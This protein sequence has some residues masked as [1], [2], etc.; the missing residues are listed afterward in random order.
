MGDV[1]ADYPV[2]YKKK[3]GT[4][5]FTK[6][7]IYCTLQ[8]STTPAVTI[9]GAD[10]TKQHVTA[11][12]AAEP[13]LKIDTTTTS[14]TFAFPSSQ[15]RDAVKE[16][17]ATYSANNGAASA[18]AQASSS[19]AMTVRKKEGPG[20]STSPRP[21][22]SGSTVALLKRKRGDV[23]VPAVEIEARKQLLSK[24]P[25]LGKL[26]RELVVTGMVDED[27][28]WEMRRSELETATFAATQKS[29]NL[30]HSLADIRPVE[31]DGNETIV[32]TTEKVHSMFLQNPALQQAYNENVPDKIPEKEFWTR[33]FQSK[34]FY[35]SRRATGS[36]ATLGQSD[37]LFDTLK[38]VLDIDAN[39]DPRRLAYDASNKLV[40]LSLTAEDHQEV[41]NAPDSTMQAGN[42]REYLPVIRKFNRIS[43]D[44]LKQTQ[45]DSNPRKKVDR[46]AK[47]MDSVYA[48]ETE[49][50]ELEAPKEREAQPLAIQEDD[51]FENQAA[52]LSNTTNGNDRHSSQGELDAFSKSMQTWL[53][54][55]SPNIAIFR[56]DAVLRSAT[57]GAKRRKLGHTTDQ[58]PSIDIYPQLVE[59]QNSTLEL[60]RHFWGA[61]SRP[62]KAAKADK[63]AG[64]LR[65]T[66][67][68]IEAFLRENSANPTAVTLM[69]STRQ[70]LEKAIKAYESRTIII[71]YMDAESDLCLI[72]EN[73]LSGTGRRKILRF[74]TM[75]HNRG[76]A[77]AV[78]GHP[79]ADRYAANNPPYWHFDECH[80]HWHFVAYADYELMSADSNNII[81]KGHKN[82]FCLEDLKC[83]P[84]YEKKYTCTNQGITMGCADIYE[85]NLACQWIDITDLDQ[86]PGYSDQTPYTLKVTINRQ[87]FFPELDYGNNARPQALVLI[88]KCRTNSLRPAGGATS[89]DND[90]LHQVDKPQQL[91]D[92]I[93]L[94]IT[95]IDRLHSRSLVAL[96]NDDSVKSNRKVESLQEE[97]NRLFQKAREN[98]KAMATATKRMKGYEGNVRRA[99]QSQLAKKLMNA[100]KYQ[101]VQESF[102]NKRKQRMEREYRVGKLIVTSGRP[103]ATASEIENAIEHASGPTYSQQILTIGVGEQRHALEEVQN[104]QVEFQKVEQ[105]IVQLFNLFQ[106]MQV[107]LDTQQE[108]IAQVDQHVDNTIAYVED[109]S[110]EMQKAVVHR[111][112][113]RKKMWY[114]FMAAIILIAVIAATVYFAFFN[115]GK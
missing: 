14:Y 25:E 46:S 81:L 50:E 53:P 67:T 2:K 103:N 31:A 42:K 98:V 17:V 47:A 83:D 89:D 19:N 104:R 73:C 69:S 79:P 85:R 96:S 43:E 60:L 71:D 39:P 65:T 51:Y 40:D 27:E 108:Q 76:T 36:S 20:K 95:A 97:T 6:S 64:T 90:F 13:K 91:I 30:Y 59:R 18:P 34:Y 68:V 23:E 92:R 82:G 66:L 63:L 16:R 32:I 45:K 112:N 22:R 111:T 58:R 74:S 77:D 75:V 26:F 4:L 57:E 93:K 35:K 29:G 72:H 52:V 9:M 38:D 54:K 114:L 8:G 62:A 94:N 102:K 5:R 11:E 24:S 48:K 7:R 87:K 41:G 105:N 113:T 80:H 107:L 3:D 100:Y 37:K 70:A 78:L 56:T 106:D 88:I 110:R 33:Y 101:G 61:F 28:F 86:T 44:V 10:I 115:N 55:F 15:A 49:L 21:S 84:G 109:G 99:Q 12:G 1:L